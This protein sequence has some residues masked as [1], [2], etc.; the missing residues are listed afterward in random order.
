MIEVREMHQ[1]SAQTPDPRI[2]AAVD[3]YSRSF[4]EVEEHFHGQIFQHLT[5]EP[6]LGKLTPGEVHRFQR[7]MKSRG[8]VVIHDAHPDALSAGLFE[9]ETWSRGEG[10]EI[11]LSQ[12]GRSL[13]RY[14]ESANPLQA[15]YDP[16]LD[17][18]DRV[19]P[20]IRG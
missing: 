14:V 1:H 20:S 2:R 18:L 19:W 9:V 15:R 4:T 17:E 13:L 11:V 7:G 5:G 8:G 16:S 3:D 12:D 6:Y 10:V